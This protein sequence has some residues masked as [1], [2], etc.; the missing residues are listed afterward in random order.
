MRFDRAG[1]AF[2]PV[3]DSTMTKTLLTL[4]LA[5]FALA[6]C[7]E[8]KPAF[9]ESA[10]PPEVPSLPEPVATPPEPAK[11]EP[12]E[13]EP[14]KP[15]TA[16]PPAKPTVGA[17][18]WAVG[19]ISLMTDD[20]VVGVPPGGKLRVVR[21]T[22]AGYVV[23][24]GKHEFPVVDSQISTSSSSGSFAAQADAAARAADRDWQKNQATQG[25]QNAV[26]SSAKQALGELQNRLHLLTREEAQLQASLRQAQ[27]DEYN[28]QVARN[29]RR[30][31]TRTISDAQAAQ[32]RARLPIVQAEKDRVFWELK[33]AQ[34]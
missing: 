15:E 3:P 16:P 33:Q 28:A 26:A 2:P 23:T 21:V 24:D 7:S 11:T 1:N 34:Q 25:A 9:A 32:W 10:P 5:A 29:Q 22:E 30:V 27:Q 14:A 4:A 8:Q 6:A 12:T 31:Y 13:T 20:G 17:E 18:V 19:R